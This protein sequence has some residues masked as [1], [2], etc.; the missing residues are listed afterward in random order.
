M[1]CGHEL[2]LPCF[3]EN[4]EQSSLQCPLCRTR[5]ASWARRSAKN[6][7]LVNLKRWAEIREA[8]P[9]KVQQRLEGKEDSASEDGRM[10]TCCLPE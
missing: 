10:L 8:F 5:I 7:K 9:E 2:C 3:K 6:K 1:P 4:V